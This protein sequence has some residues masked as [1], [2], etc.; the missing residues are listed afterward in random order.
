VKPT[1]TLLF[2]FLLIET[3][4]A[5][6]AADSAPNIVPNPGFEQF[7]GQPVGWYYKGA[8]FGQVVKYWQS[9]TTASPDAY[10]PKVRVPDTWAEKGFGKF[11]PHSGKNNVGITVY[12]CTNGKPH[13][14]EYIEILL[15]E[16]LVIGQ[17]YLTEFWV[18][19]LP[20]SLQI[21]QLGAIFTLEKID[22]KTDE[23]LLLTPQIRAEN[24]VSAAANWTK[25]TGKFVATEESNW[26]T[27]GNFSSDEN[28]KTENIAGE[29]SLNFAYYYLDD[30]LVKKV[31]PF[32]PLL[33]RPDDLTKLTL[34]IGDTIRLRDIYFEFDQSELLPRSFVELNKLAKI[35]KENPRMNIQ[36]LGH[37]D[38]D[39]DEKYNRKLSENRAKTV[40]NWLKKQGIKENRLQNKGF[41]ETKPIA[42]NDTDIGKQANRR[43]EFVVLRR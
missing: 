42:T 9:A 19:S 35:L 24:I 20:K 11:K 16:P 18:A 14:R 36:I 13:C 34:K 39:G 8:H 31:P 2:F 29:M 22:K 25:I 32:K 10:S 41:G 3:I 5:Q 1:A 30:V 6:T 26:L 17:S 4:A 7:I 33:V 15:A 27:I 21:N 40:E 37:T 12:G 43:V 23:Q 38:S 28:T